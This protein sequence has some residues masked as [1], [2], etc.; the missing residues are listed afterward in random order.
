VGETRGCGVLSGVFDGESLNLN[1]AIRGLKAVKS[2]P[3]VFFR[4]LAKLTQRVGMDLC[5]CAGD[6]NPRETRGLLFPMV[7]NGGE[8]G[9]RTLGTV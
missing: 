6:V 9:I 8:G 5:G 1:A 4:G 2:G 3:R 7:I